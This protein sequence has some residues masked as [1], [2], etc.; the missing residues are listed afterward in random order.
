M[1]SVAALAGREDEDEV[2][3]EMAGGEG[4]GVDGR[5]VSGL[6]VGVCCTVSAVAVLVLGVSDVVLLTLLVLSSASA[7]SSS[8]IEG[9]GGSMLRSIS[10]K[11]DISARKSDCGSGFP[12]KRARS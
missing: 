1:G 6:G 7:W 9:S 5:C 2:A 8:I 11:M 10:A 3:V 12:E 4:E